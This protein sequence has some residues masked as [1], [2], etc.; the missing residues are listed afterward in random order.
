MKGPVHLPAAPRQQLKLFPPF[1]F[2]HGVVFAT[3]AGGDAELFRLSGRWRIA[4]RSA[5]HRR[6]RRVAPA[7]GRSEGQHRSNPLGREGAPS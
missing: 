3:K 1:M 2:G 7:D 6:H 5:S 4:S